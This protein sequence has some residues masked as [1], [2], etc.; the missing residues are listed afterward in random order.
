MTPLPTIRQLQ[1][2]T[3]LAR[4]GSFSSAAE[5]CFVSQSTLSSAIK[6]L[7][8]LLGKQLVD[9]STRTVSLTPAGQEVAKMAVQLLAQAEDIVTFT[10]RSEPL[11]S[12]F[13]LGVIPTVAPFLLPQAMP[14]LRASYPKLRLYLKEDLSAKLLEQ[15]AI[16]ALDVVIL[17]LPYSFAGVE[18]R[19]IGEDP[20][21][22]AGHPEHPL[23]SEQAISREAIKAENLLLLEDGHCLRDHALDACSLRD[24]KSTKTYSATSLF[25]LTQMV[26]SGLGST[27]LPG[28]AVE[29]GLAEAS[30]LAVRPIEKPT[31]SRKIGVA[32]RRGSGRSE[33][34]ALIGEVFADFLG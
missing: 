34:A 17:A 16:G 6:E 12:E 24:P 22:F 11:A 32:W 15:L 33:E 10:K 30:G 23:L 19:E 21:L 8:G 3:A 27:L 7:E 25:T 26:R 13:H 1:F 31:P 18:T 28:M 29:A 5:D 2:F 20:F 14:V 9:R 4:R